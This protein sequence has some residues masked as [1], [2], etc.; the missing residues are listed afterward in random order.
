MD[1]SRTFHSQKQL[2]SSASCGNAVDSPGDTLWTYDEE[3]LISLNRHLSALF[4]QQ[5]TNAHIFDTLQLWSSSNM[6]LTDC[7][8]H[9]SKVWSCWTSRPPL[10]HLL[11]RFPVSRCLVESVFRW[12]T[13]VLESSE[14]RLDVP[15]SL[16]SAKGK[17]LVGYH[18]HGW[19]LFFRFSL[20]WV[21]QIMQTIIGI[22]RR[23]NR[24]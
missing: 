5:H 12:V 7:F 4:T 14:D 3:T 20:G 13:A 16:Q 19:K 15:L 6:N 1:V 21:S 23:R 11:L 2:W 17:R 24:L 22:M 9:R 10:L 8:Q 18:W